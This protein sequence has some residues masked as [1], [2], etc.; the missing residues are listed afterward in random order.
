MAVPESCDFF[1]QWTVKTVA[2][3]QDTRS[4]GSEMVAFRDIAS[5]IEPAESK[6][7]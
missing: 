5:E 3:V 7:E 4:S 1:T 2:A 6:H